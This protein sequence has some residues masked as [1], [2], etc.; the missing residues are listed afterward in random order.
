MNPSSMPR[1]SG[2]HPERSRSLV[3]PFLLI[4]LGALFL[5]RN[6]MPELALLDYL[7]QYWPFLL[8]LWGSLRLLEIAT[9]SARGQALPRCGVSGGEWVLAIFL[10]LI[11]AS[12]HAARGFPSWV[13][14]QLPGVEVFGESYEYLIDAQT[15]T[16]PTATP[17]IVLDG[18]RGDTRIVGV[19]GN[20][21]KVQGRY[22]V[23]A[24]NQ[25]D[26]DDISH[27]MK[28]SLVESG[29]QVTIRV[30]EPNTIGRGRSKGGY[31]GRIAT[32]L[33]IEVPRGAS[34]FTQGHSGGMDVTAIRGTVDL[35][36]RNMDVRLEDIGGKV[37]LDL[38]GSDL[39]RAVNLQSDLNL[40]GR[41]DNIDLE[42]IAGEVT[43]D[44]QWGGLSQARALAKPIHWN[45]GRT[46]FS[47]KSLTGD[48]RVSVGDLS[49]AR[50]T[51]LRLETTYPKDLDISDISGSLTVRT[52]R[53]DVRVRSV[54]A[55][56][57]TLDVRMESGNFDL[58]VP[59]AAK[60][61]IAAETEIGDI[62]HGLDN[63]ATQSRQSR[64]ASL[65]YTD[66]GPRMEIHLERGDVAIHHL[67]KNELPTAPVQPVR[68][69]QP[70]KPP[71]SSPPRPIE[72]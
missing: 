66:G 53:G 30:D 63:R 10:C 69:V 4:G 9:W 21:V 12:L 35:K 59:L 2:P 27:N 64:G 43:V 49:I 38:E 58:T 22:R 41:G 7:A 29:G 48:L 65:N 62:F 55:P 28:V 60:M 15:I 16:A 13:G 45:T 36:G 32:D 34:V 71:S 54:T 70:L 72:Q 17:K 44:G 6:V 5:A 56:L 37:Q 31:I 1:P 23:R 24:M 46:E 67:D 19:D 42:T 11:G 39:V 18:F 14:I 68:P 51:D 40:R 25:S 33:E 57:P 3:G 8:I 52:N 50:A 26:G 20:T 47:A 61:T